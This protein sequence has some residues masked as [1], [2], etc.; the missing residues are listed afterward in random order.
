MNLTKSFFCGGRYGVLINFFILSIILLGMSL[1]LLI[2]LGIVIPATCLFFVDFFGNLMGYNEPAAIQEYLKQPIFCKTFWCTL[3]LLF[4]ITF[5]GFC[6]LFTKIILAGWTKE[7]NVEKSF[8]VGSVSTI[9]LLFFVQAAG[10]L[11]L[12]LDNEPSMKLLPQFCSV[13]LIPMVG[14]IGI[15]LAFEALF[16]LGMCFSKCLKTKESSKCDLVNV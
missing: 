15:C 11:Y 3:I 7:T 2:F 4:Q 6:H 10:T 12:S 16:Y 9:Y 14:V 5:G 13:L 8:G 1:L